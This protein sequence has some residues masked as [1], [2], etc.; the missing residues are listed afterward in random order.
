MRLD[1]ISSASARHR[2]RSSKRYSHLTQ[3]QIGP[4]DPHTR[5][6]IF[7]RLLVFQYKLL[8]D[9]VKDF[10]LSPLAMIA[11][12]IDIL[13]PGPSS[14]MLFPALMKLGHRAEE[15]INL[16]GRPVK[17]EEWTVDRLVDSVES[18]IRHRYRGAGQ[19][20]LGGKETGRD[21]AEE[22]ER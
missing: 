15:A 3:Q 22:Y 12:F 14:R 9:A 2:R 10:L 4:E 21:R 6:Q 18:S 20:G 17:D 16:F 11:A 7:R 13:H 8:V 1:H 5:W 19:D